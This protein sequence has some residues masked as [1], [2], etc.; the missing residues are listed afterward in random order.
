MAELGQLDTLTVAA[1]AVAATLVAALAAMFVAAQVEAV[2]GVAVAVLIDLMQS[3]S[4]PW[5]A[6]VSGCGRTWFMHGPQLSFI[7][8]WVPAV[9]APRPSV[10]GGPA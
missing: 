1:R 5:F 3:S 10:F 6:H 9:Q 2:G 8:V 4:L 7:H